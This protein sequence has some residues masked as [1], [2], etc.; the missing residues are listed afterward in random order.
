M[1]CCIGYFQLVVTPCPRVN[2]RAFRGM[3]YVNSRAHVAVV[4]C[5]ADRLR[6]QLPDYVKQDLMDGIALLP[7]WAVPIVKQLQGDAT[8]VSPK[9]V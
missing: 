4:V 7:S 3:Q 8:L 1:L 9:R 6:R 5:T 2:S